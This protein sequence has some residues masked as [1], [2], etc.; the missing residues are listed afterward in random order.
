MREIRAA[1]QSRA[2]PGLSIAADRP[3]V[4]MMA[5]A[6]ILPAASSSLLFCLAT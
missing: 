1:D 5:V 2:Q 6:T 3:I 4:P